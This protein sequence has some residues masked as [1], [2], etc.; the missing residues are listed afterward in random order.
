VHVS[1][2]YT[3]AAV[4]SI[5]QLTKA[6]VDPEIDSLI[7]SLVS[8]NPKFSVTVPQQKQLSRSAGR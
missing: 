4:K 6:Y 1:Y 3:F 8:L 2:P 5:I 7:P